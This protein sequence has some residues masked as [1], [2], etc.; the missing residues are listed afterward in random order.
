MSEVDGISFSKTGINPLLL[1]YLEQEPKVRSLYNSFPKKK[2]FFTQAQKKLSQYQNR[3]ILVEVLEKQMNQLSLTE[4]QKQNLTWLKKNNTVTITTGHQLNLMTG[5]LYFIYKILQTVKTCDILNSEKQN[6]HFVPIYWMA[7]EDHDFQEINHFYA[8][9]KKWKWESLQKGPVG[10]FNLNGLDEVLNQFELALPNNRFA[11]KLKGFIANS[12]LSSKNLAQATRKLVHEILG[13]YGILILDA[14]DAHLKK[15]MIPYFKNDLNNNTAYKEHI[16]S[17]FLTQNYNEQAYIRPIN[18]FY[19]N[20]LG[21]NRIEKQKHTFKV[22]DTPLEFTEEEML[23]TLQKYPEKF[24]PNVIL[25]PLYQ[26]IILPNVAYIG[27]GGEIAYWLQLKSFFD[28]EKVLFP[29]LMIRNSVLV[30]T[31]NQKR[32][33]KKLNYWGEN[34]FQSKNK[35]IKNWVTQ[36]NKLFVELDEKQK[37]LERLFESLTPIAKA[38]NVTFNDMLQAQKQKQK[39]GFAKLKKRLIKAET[40]NHQEEIARFNKLNQAFFPNG[41]WQERKINFSQFYVV[42]GDL[43]FEKVYRALTPFDSQFLVVTI[44]KNT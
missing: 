38:T 1:D 28:T 12:Y 24:S 25:R 8:F 4:K 6:I 16:S 11:D 3:S 21:R 43:F 29:L 30:V 15:L 36:D 42:Y 39:N 34:L 35:W 5:P 33:A 31:K 26:E 32:K 9:Q 22:V 13:E 19:L 44:D 40:E 37:E 17:D 7:T 10:E 14:N 41:V 23:E 18:L 27:G 20:E 2:A